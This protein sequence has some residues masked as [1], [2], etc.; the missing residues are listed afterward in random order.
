MVR[1][2]CDIFAHN[3]QTNKQTKLLG[4]SKLFSN[5]RCQTGFPVECSFVSDNARHTKPLEETEL[6][7]SLLKAWKEV[8]RKV[9][10]KIPLWYREPCAEAGSPS[11]ETT[12]L[13]RVKQ[14]QQSEASGN[15]N[16]DQTISLLMTQE[17]TPM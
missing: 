15:R 12:C 2:I 6:Q 11:R 14:L 16:V 9:S 1:Y 8:K 10:Q 17:D 4:A 5:H 7:N 13:E 3:I